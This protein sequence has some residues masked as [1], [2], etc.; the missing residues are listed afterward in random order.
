M[1]RPYWLRSSVAGETVFMLLS[2]YVPH[3]E[4][5]FVVR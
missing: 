2:G 4:W 5:L 3:L 1:A